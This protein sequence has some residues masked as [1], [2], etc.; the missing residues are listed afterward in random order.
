MLSG[1]TG[2]CVNVGCGE[3]GETKTTGVS[4]NT[5]TTPAQANI[6]TNISAPQFFM[7][8]FMIPSLL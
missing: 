2:A 6:N 1:V 7:D 3:M 5:T 4:A 8:S